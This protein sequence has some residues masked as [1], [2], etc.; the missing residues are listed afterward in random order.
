MSCS[1]PKDQG[2]FG[3]EVDRT[4]QIER[5]QF[6]DKVVVGLVVPHFDREVEYYPEN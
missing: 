6:G 3:E 5:K 1:S 4:I 2:A